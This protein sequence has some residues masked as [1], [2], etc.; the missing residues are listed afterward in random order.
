MNILILTGVDIF[1]IYTRTN[2]VCKFLETKAKEIVV[3]HCGV[4]K[5]L[6]EE[7]LKKGRIVNIIK[8]PSRYVCWWSGSSIYFKKIA[9]KVFSNCYFDYCFVFSPFLIE[10]GIELKN[11]KIIKKLV[12]EDL[13]E[14]PAFYPKNS[15]EY[16]Y[17]KNL[18]TKALNKADIV[19][20]S[21]EG[22]QKLHAD[23][24]ET[25]HKFLIPNGTITSYFDKI[26]TLPRKAPI[27][28]YSGAL[29]RWAA[30][31]IP[32][33]AL[34]IIKEEIPNV[35]LWIIGKGAYK[36]K[37]EK[38]VSKLKVEK[39]V[40][41]IGRKDYKELPIFYKKAKIGVVTFKKSLLTEVALPLKLMDY[42]G[43]GLCVLGSNFG[44]IKKIIQYSKCGFTIDSVKDFAEKAIKILKDDKLYNLFRQNIF[45]K[46][47][48]FDINYLYEKHF[49]NIFQ[50]RESKKI[51]EKARVCNVSRILENMKATNMVELEDE[52]FASFR[53]KIFKKILLK[54][55]GLMNKRVLLYGTGEASKLWTKILD[56]YHVNIVGYMDKTAKKEDM[57]FGKKVFKTIKEI[58]VPYD[59]I[60]LACQPSFHPIIKKRL[61][62]QKCNKPIISLYW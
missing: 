47:K 49:N 35:E 29:E 26:R 43:A 33:K 54:K 15:F 53:K 58:N 40:V 56:G 36:T 6:I 27:L 55:I 51:P 23:L 19:I 62:R 3:V 57:F 46:F 39:N 38:L 48:E 34:P 28:I 9:N 13:D 59:A 42:I 50:K 11:K 4:T 32:I 10:L 60:I 17:L 7:P 21:S 24:T 31:D 25:P 52:V 44:E 12:Y 30:I 18:Q 45:E 2:Q 20:F 14:F 1:E 37:L 16:T 8:L 5:N 22:L 41:F 61:K